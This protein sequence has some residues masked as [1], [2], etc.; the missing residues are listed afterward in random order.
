MREQNYNIKERRHEK[1]SNNG[2]RRKCRNGLEERKLVTDK[3]MEIKE[4]RTK[5][6]Q[7]KGR[8]KGD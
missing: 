3:R 8:E 4:K 1:K 7:G 5:R 2:R 6:E